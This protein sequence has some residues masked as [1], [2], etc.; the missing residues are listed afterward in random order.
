MLD[1]RPTDARVLKLSSVFETENLIDFLSILLN[2]WTWTDVVPSAASDPD[3][4][5][6]STKH[7]S[8]SQTQNVFLW[9]LDLLD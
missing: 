2:K 6:Q 1:Q 8:F 3:P 7:F 4:P 5:A 9:V